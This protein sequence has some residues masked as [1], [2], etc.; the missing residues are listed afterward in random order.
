[1]LEGDPLHPPG[2]AHLL[3]QCL[4]FC[5]FFAPFHKNCGGARSNLM[6]KTRQTLYENVIALFPVRVTLRFPMLPCWMEDYKV[7]VQLLAYLL[8]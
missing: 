3:Q 1:M 6:Y 4:A 8:T 5:H 2:Y 7:G